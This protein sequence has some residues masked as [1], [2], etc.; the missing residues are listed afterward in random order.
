[1]I[2]IIIIIIIIHHT[3]EC[4]QSQSGLSHEVH[5]RVDQMHDQ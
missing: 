5:K 2:I 3:Q 4:T 1:M